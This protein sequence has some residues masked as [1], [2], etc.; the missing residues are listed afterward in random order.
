MWNVSA[1]E[2]IV[3]KSNN[4]A[5]NGKRS[6]I[7]KNMLLELCPTEPTVQIIRIF[8]EQETPWGIRPCLAFKEGVNGV[9][10]PLCRISMPNPRRM[11]GGERG[12]YVVGGQI[13]LHSP[14]LHYSALSSSIARGGADYVCHQLFWDRYDAVHAQYPCSCRSRWEEWISSR[15]PA[16]P[17]LDLHDWIRFLF[18]G[19]PGPPC[20][21]P[22]CAFP[23]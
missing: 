1:K 3:L 17:P 18:S 8:W 16:W 2:L 19:I 5:N 20:Y 21:F 9:T 13:Q 4:D 7:L 11:G 14:A 23:Q 15:K 22:D 10:F 6:E 12:V